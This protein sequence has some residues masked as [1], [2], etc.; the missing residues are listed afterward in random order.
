MKVVERL[1]KVTGRCPVIGG[2]LV[3]LLDVDELDEDELDECDDDD[4][5]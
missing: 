4:E 3:L 1:R 5:L 2:M